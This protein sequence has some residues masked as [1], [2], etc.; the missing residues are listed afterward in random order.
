MRDITPMVQT[1]HLLT[2]VGKRQP[3]NQT[4]NKTPRV[5]K[6]SMDKIRIFLD[7]KIKTLLDQRGVCVSI[8]RV[9]N[10]YVPQLALK[11]VQVRKSDFHLESYLV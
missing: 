4:V 8:Q 10:V 5:P 1:P 6:I 11:G 2:L 7:V 3:C 9:N